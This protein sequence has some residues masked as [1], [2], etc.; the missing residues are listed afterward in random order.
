MFAINHAATA[1]IIKR[2]F[3]AAPMIWLLVCVQ[4]MEPSMG[5]VIRQ[6]MGFGDTTFHVEK[7]RLLHGF[8][9]RTRRLTCD[10]H[11]TQ[12]RLTCHPEISVVL[13]NYCMGDVK[14][15]FIS[16]FVKSV[17]AV[18]RVGFAAPLEV[19]LERIPDSRG[20]VDISASVSLLASVRCG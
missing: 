8:E 16:D 15:S 9:M 11:E 19:G 13:R 1:L 18:I 17:D 12:V 5:T 6:N 10:S 14:P 7:F 20:R 4:V 3:P 2:R